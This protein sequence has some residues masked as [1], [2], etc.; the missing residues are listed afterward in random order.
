MRY[1]QKT[2]PEKQERN[3]QNLVRNWTSSQLFHIFIVILIKYSCL[4]LYVLSSYLTIL[5]NGSCLHQ[6]LSDSYNLT[7][8]LETSDI[9]GNNI[10]FSKIIFSLLDGYR[11]PKQ[12]FPCLN[13]VCNLIDLPQGLL[14]I[15]TLVLQSSFLTCYTRLC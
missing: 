13:P 7:H 8:L 9:L 4:L 11:I 12:G 6:D 15:D 2:L 10:I 5:S 14:S 1:W 3:W